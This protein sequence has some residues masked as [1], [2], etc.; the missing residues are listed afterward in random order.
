MLHA[1][2]LEKVLRK[3]LRK[4]LRKV[5]YSFGCFVG[6]VRKVFLKYSFAGFQPFAEDKKLKKR[7]KKLKKS[8][9]KL[10]GQ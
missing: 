4:D 2:P 8:I 10:K 7:I 5:V 1:M 3:D 9:K 6:T